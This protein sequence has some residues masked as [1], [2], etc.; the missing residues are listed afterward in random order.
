MRRVSE[1]G[2][3]SAIRDV[4]RS[5]H[6]R[7]NKDLFIQSNPSL[8]WQIGWLPTLVSGARGLGRRQHIYSD[9]SALTMSLTL[10]LPRMQ[11]LVRLGLRIRAG[12]TRL[13]VK[14]KRLLHEAI[15]P[16]PAVVGLLAA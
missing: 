11:V 5:R 3:N 10:S 15:R 12:L 16:L 4:R 7:A 9:V 6:D 1:Y 13:V 2:D 14:T 8:R